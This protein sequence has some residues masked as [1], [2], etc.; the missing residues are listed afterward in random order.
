MK[1]DEAALNKLRQYTQAVKALQKAVEKS[2]TQGMIEGTGRMVAKNYRGLH[3]KIVELMPDDY[4]ITDTLALELDDNASD[5]QILGQVQLA[6]TQMIIY[7][8]GQIKE[9]GRTASVSFSTVEGADFRSLGRDLQEQ[10]VNLTRTTLRRALTNVDVDVEIGKHRHGTNLRDA[11][12]SGRDMH[13]AHLE[14]ANLRD[15]NAESINLQGAFLTG[16]EFRGANLSSA[17]LEGANMEGANFVDT[18]LE[19][20]NMAG[21][22]ADGINLK[23]SN[24]ENATMEGASMEGA[25]LRD[26]NLE[27]VNLSAANL[28]GVNMRG[29]NAEGANLTGARLNGANL[30]DA[31]LER[32]NLTDARLNGAILPDGAIYISGMNLARYGVI[33]DAEKPKNDEEER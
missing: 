32:A 4:F 20:A 23:N 24:L 25:N 28:S 12:L 3:A 9:S 11:D 22:R 10:I 16:A 31:N 21:V 17:N 15:V 13:G 33:V 18:N 2:I 5:E 1:M 27:G 29:A 6:A 30:R 19:N 26:A 8:E 7:L 14:G